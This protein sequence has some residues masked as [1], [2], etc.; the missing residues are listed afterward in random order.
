VGLERDCDCAA[1]AIANHN[2]SD[3][4]TRRDCQMLQIMRTAPVL[5]AST[6]ANAL[7]PR[8]NCYDLT[9]TLRHL[10]FDIH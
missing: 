2:H 6:I 7:S 8:M 3:A 5:V 1:V 4:T 10:Y 9:E